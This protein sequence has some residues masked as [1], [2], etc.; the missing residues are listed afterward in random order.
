MNHPVA[1]PLHRPLLERWAHDVAKC[2]VSAWQQHRARRELD[3][4]IDALSELSAAALRDI[5][6]PD[7]LP[8]RAAARREANAQRIDQMPM[9]AGYRG[10]DSRAW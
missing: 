1:I 5:G 2:I 8:S 6:W 7:D 4:R 9:L 10:L 3:L